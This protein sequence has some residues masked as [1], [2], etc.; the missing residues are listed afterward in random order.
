MR[1]VC[2]AAGQR[3][4]GLGGEP[5]SLSDLFRRVVA[6]QRE[7]AIGVAVGKVRHLNAL[8]RNDGEDHRGGDQCLGN[9]FDGEPRIGTRPGQRQARLDLDEPR[10]T[11]VADTPPLRM[12]PAVANRR[13]PRFEKVRTEGDDEI[14]VG[15][16]VLRNRIAAERHPVRSPDRLVCE[17]LVPE[18]SRAH[19]GRPLVDESIQRARH[20]GGHDRDASRPTGVASGLQLLDKDALGVVPADILEPALPRHGVRVAPATRAGEA[21]GVVQPLQRCVT[22]DA[23]GSPVDRMVRVALDLHGAALARANDHPAPGRALSAHR[24]VPRGDTGN[25][26]LRRHDVRNDP[27]GR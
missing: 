20:Q 15:E 25:N 26:I 1:G 2:K 3:A 10:G 11:P 18:P 5:R 24:C 21:V 8:L 23:Q 14:G 12:I 17:R 13:Q 22:P 16:V 19:R 4:N 7:D 6:H 27:F 9:W